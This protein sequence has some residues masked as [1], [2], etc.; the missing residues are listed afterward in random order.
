MYDVIEPDNE[1]YYLFGDFIYNE[2]KDKMEISENINIEMF[3]YIIGK[4]Y[5]EAILGYSI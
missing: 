5:M 2:I 4:L 1:I 3:K